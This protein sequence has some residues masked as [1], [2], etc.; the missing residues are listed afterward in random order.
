VQRDNLCIHLRQ[1]EDISVYRRGGMQKPMGADRYTFICGLGGKHS[2][3][4]CPYGWNKG[5]ECPDYKEA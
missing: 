2:K 3:R 1:K 4:V 5:N